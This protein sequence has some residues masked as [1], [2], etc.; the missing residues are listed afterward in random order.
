MKLFLIKYIK[1]EKER[2][3]QIPAENKENALIGFGATFSESWE[4][5]KIKVISV[6][7]I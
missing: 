4:M 7:V 2:K 3:Y 5:G 1:E 6:E